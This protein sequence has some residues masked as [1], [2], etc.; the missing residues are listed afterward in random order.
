M[1]LLIRYAAYPAIITVTL[2]AA[3]MVASASVPAWPVLAVVAAVGIGLVAVLERLLPF[4]LAWIADQGD[5]RADVAH[6]LVN[7][8]L[9]SGGAV[10]VHAVTQAVAL[11][12]VWPTEWPVWAQLLAIAAVF[13][14]GLYVMHVLSHRWPWAWRLHAI[15]HSAERLYWL[16]GER[17]HPLSAA[18]MAA[19]G[20]LTL[21]LLGAPPLIVSSWLAVVAVHLAFQHANLD[22]R[23]GPLRRW[24]AGAE[25]HRWHQKR[26]YEDAQVN[27]GEFL[28]VW[29]RLFGTYIDPVA[30]MR[31]DEVGLRRRD[32][33]AAYVGQFLWPFCMPAELRRAF[34]ARLSAGE[35]ALRSSRAD[36]AMQHFEAAHILGQEWTGPHVRS[37]VAI[38]RWALQQRRWREI[39][40]Q[41]TRI[42]A[43]V[44][45]TWLWVPRGNPGSTR[46][47]ALARRPVPADLA[48]LLASANA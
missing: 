36:E 27:F 14:L 20:L 12:A 28:L 34:Q 9:L 39:M 38:L 13:D 19:P 37:H 42:V 32:M 47:G 17:R 18:L 48:A 21:A 40:G 1:A 16:N 8:A 41:V 7:W 3:L 46:V 45:F 44:L 25:T 5:T 35:E 15:H 33:P 4:E 2:G 43:A 30:S 6:G 29:D 26:E 22:Y 31:A 11:P 24:I 23:L 10:V